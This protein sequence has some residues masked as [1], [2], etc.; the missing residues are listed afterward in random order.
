VKVLPDGGFATAILDAVWA[1][2]PPD[3]IA[4]P[5]PLLQ[6]EGL[7]PGRAQR[8]LS[9]AWYVLKGTPLSDDDQFDATA[10]LPL[11]FV[12]CVADEASLAANLLRSL[13]LQPGSPH[14]LLLYR[15]CQ[16]AADGL[17]RGL[18]QARHALVVC[19]HQDVY[20]PDGWPRRFLGQ[21]AAAE[22]ALGPPGVAGVYGVTCRGEAVGRAGHVMDRDRL[23]REPPS[24]PRAV[25]TLDELLLALPRGTPLRFDP[26]LGFHF[27]GAD[28][29]LQARQRG[30]P[31]AALDALCFHNSNGVGLPPAF[32]ESARAFAQK[33]RASLPLATSCVHIDAAGRL[34]LA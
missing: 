32:A 21:Y 8:Y 4:A 3:F 12:G 17:N 6:R 2:R 11:T 22:R 25:D 27:Y 16:S 34:R 15:G 18:T 5:A 29:C 23:L 26:R 1:P 24:L 30:L 14:E 20:L 28:A 10:E 19:L 33:W 7:H 9:A 31:A 13:C